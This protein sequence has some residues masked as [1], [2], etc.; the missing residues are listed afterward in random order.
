RAR[1]ISLFFPIESAVVRREY[2]AARADRPA[3]FPI[4]GK[5]DGV[6]RVSLW[7]RVLPLPTAKWVLCLGDKRHNEQQAEQFDSERERHYF[8]VQKVVDKGRRNYIA[9]DF[10]GST[11]HDHSA[12]IREDPWLQRFRPYPR[13]H[14]ESNPP[15]VRRLLS[16]VRRYPRLPEADALR[17]RASIPSEFCAPR[18]PCR[19]VATTEGSPCA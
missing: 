12:L 4:R 2:D 15:R 17:V 9:T 6:D 18:R 7:E 8:I 11:R 19:V 3:A 5:S 16:A 13:R 1:R 14:A 10:H